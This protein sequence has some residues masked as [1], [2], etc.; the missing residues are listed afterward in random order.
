MKNNMILGAIIYIICSFNHMAAQII[1]FDNPEAELQRAR[2]G[3][4]DEFIKQFNGHRIHPDIKDSE[5][6]SINMNLLWLFDH[7]QFVNMN[8]HVQDSLRAE[9][10]NFID[11]IKSNHININYSDSEWV[12]I[13]HCKGIVMGKQEIFDIFLT[14]QSRGDDMYKWVINAVEGEC[15][16]VNPKNINKNLIISPE[17]HETKF[18]ALQRIL[19]EQPYNIQLYMADNVDYDPTSV[20]TYLA[21]SGKLKIEYVEKL[22]FIFLQVPNY[23]FHIQYFDRNSNNSGWLISNFYHFSDTDKAAF[24]KMINQ[25]IQ[26]Q[27]VLKN[28]SKTEESLVGVSIDTPVNTSNSFDVN[29]ILNDRIDERIKQLQNYIS[30]IDTCGIKSSQQYYKNKLIN[31]F[32]PDANAIIKIAKTGETKVISLKK[33]AEGLLSKKYSNMEIEAI[34]S[35]ILSNYGNDRDERNFLVTGIIPLSLMDTDIIIN[36][37]YNKMPPCHLEDTEDGIEYICDFGDIYISIN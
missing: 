25:D 4:V 14:V 6:D 26:P 10:L 16:N 9:A 15:F 35:V 5:Y 11:I 31:L 13:A 33:F 29:N 28:D 37:M 27:K 23:A 36:R 22:E 18:I 12:A 24:R 17:A 32:S 34:T 2:I 1:A 21:Y 3:L 30:Y 8:Q 7:D 19:K 20:F